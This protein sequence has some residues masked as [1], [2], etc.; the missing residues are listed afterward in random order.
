MMTYGDLHY[1][2][3]RQQPL[4]QTRGIMSDVRSGGGRKR[5]PRHRAPAAVKRSPSLGSRSIYRPLLAWYDRHRRDLPWR[6]R[7]GDPYAQLLAEFMLQQTQVSTVLGYYERFLRRFPTVQALAKGNLDDVLT[8]WSGLGYYSRARN[9]HAAARKIAEEYGGVVPGTVEE[10]MTLPGIGRYTA[11]AIASIAYGVR[12]PV[13]DGNVIRVLMRLLAIEADPK[14]PRVRSQLWDQAAKLLPR[15]RCGDFN[16]ALMELGATLCSPRTPDC[17]A[18]PLKRCCRAHLRCLTDRI[19]PAAR[20]TRVL[21]A[22]MVVAA[23]R[24]K[25]ELLFVQRPTSGL[26][27]GLWEL[28]SEF[29]RDGESLAP[30]RKR[31][32]AT[33]PIRCRL[34]RSPVGTVTR[35]LTHRRIAF[36]VFAAAPTSR[37]AESGWQSPPHLRPWR[38]VR[39]EQLRTLGISRACEAIIEMLETKREGDRMRT[40]G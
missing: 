13:L 9:L 18:C 8:L 1:G 38:W 4:R 2:T 29:V 14:S 30:A 16:Q 33:L 39:P 15:K 22:R 34:S 37:A 12:A 28:P 24:R 10:L 6:R 40:T 31:L 19:P 3:R 25:Q 23:I 21:P 26:W 17:G 36:E 20:P 27:G 32:Q 5:E 7:A 35:R 11:G